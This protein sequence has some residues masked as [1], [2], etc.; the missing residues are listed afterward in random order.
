MEASKDSDG[1]LDRRRS[2]F[3]KLRGIFTPIDE[4]L[5]R[6]AFV[7]TSLRCTLVD[8]AMDVDGGFHS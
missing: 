6:W 7:E 4:R 1:S 3:M 8:A 5:L 2:T